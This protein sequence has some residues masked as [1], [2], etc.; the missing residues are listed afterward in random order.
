MLTLKKILTKKW[1]S[2]RVFKMIE[3]KPIKYIYMNTR[4]TLIK[5]L[6]FNAIKTGADSRSYYLRGN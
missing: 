6:L 3:L 4:N 2:V 1:C 5:L